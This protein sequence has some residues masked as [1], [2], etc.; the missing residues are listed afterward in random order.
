[1]S[2]L[3]QILAIAVKNLK[4]KFRNW[5]TY[6]YTFGFPI[7]FTLI[8]YFALGQP[9]DPVIPG[10][11]DWVIFDFGFAGM[12]IYTASFGTINAASAFSHE[13]YQGTLVRL[14]TTPVGRGKIF[15]GT[16]ISES[17]TLVIMLVLMFLLGYGALGVHM[18]EQN[19]GL[20]FIGFLIMFIFGLSTVGLGIIISAY[21]KTEDAAIGLAMMYVLP[22]TFL[23]GAMMPLESNLVYAFPPFYA[24]Q[25]YKQVV[26]LGDNFWTTNLAFN[27][28]YNKGLGYTNIPLWGAFLIIIAFL[29]VTLIVGIL[30]FQRK[31]LK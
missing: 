24:F 26:L 5:H 31:T 30:L 20:L 25:A 12:L 9:F 14:D 10:K 8:F 6:L 23:S 27:D 16:L 4:L 22:I 15:I 7:M 11:E 29:V 18:H 1:M 17:V 13:K 3:D 19:V 28:P 21:A 2:G